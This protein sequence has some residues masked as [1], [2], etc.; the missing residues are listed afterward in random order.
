MPNHVTN[1]LRAPKR[2]IDALAGENGEIDFATIVPQP[3]NLEQG[4]CSGKH[5]P[6]II[7]WYDWQVQN[8]GT[9][10][11]A[12]DIE[13]IAD[14]EIRFDTAWSTPTPIWSRI[15]KACG[16]E[17]FEANYADED[18]GHNCGRFEW[19]GTTLKHTAPESGSAAAME[20][21]A[22]TKYGMTF[23]EWAKDWIDESYPNCAQCGE[24]WE[25]GEA[26]EVY[27]KHGLC[28]DCASEHGVEFERTAVFERIEPKALEN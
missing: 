12:Y 20:H 24:E 11:N 19:D 27:S 25:S 10:W 1:I 21:A 14:N 8:W 9:K 26:P 23:L 5:A 15:A 22:R 4:G 6:G 7:C 18:F 16:S 17:H 2:V 28:E 13:R 3:P